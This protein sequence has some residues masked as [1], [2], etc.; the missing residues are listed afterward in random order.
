MKKINEIKKLLI[1]FLVIFLFLFLLADKV[2]AV[3]WVC[4]Y[5]L[6]LCEEYIGPAENTCCRS[7]SCSSNCGTIHYWDWCNAIDCCVDQT[8]WYNV[9]LVYDYEPCGARDT[10]VATKYL[11]AG[12]CD[13]GGCSKGGFYKICCEVNASGN[14]TGNICPHVCSGANYTGTCGS[15]CNPFIG[16]SCPAGPTPTGTPAPTPTP[17]P[18]W[19]RCWCR[20]PVANYCNLECCWGTA[21][22]CPGK[23]EAPT[24]CCEGGGPAECEDVDWIQ[25]PDEQSCPAGTTP[26]LLS[27]PNT[28]LGF[29]TGSL[30]PWGVEYGPATVGGCNWNFCPAQE[31]NYIL[32]D[33]VSND[34]FRVDQRI[35]GLT[36]GKSYLVSVWGRA[37]SIKPDS[38]DPCLAKNQPQIKLI[39]GSNVNSWT[40]ISRAR[41]TW[42]EQV[43]GIT[44]PPGVDWIE[45]QLR[46]DCICD[47]WGWCYQS[48]MDWVR[49]Y[50]CTPPMPPPTC[51]GMSAPSCINTGGTF[52]VS[53]LGVQNATSVKFP[54]WDTQDGQEDIVWYNGVQS[55]STW[56]VNIN[57]SAHP[58][59]NINVHVYMF[60]ASHSNVWC[61]G[62]NDI[63]LCAPDPWFQTKGGDVHGNSDV[64]TTIPPSLSTYF[65]LDPAGVPSTGRGLGFTGNIEGIM[66]SPPPGWQVADGTEVISGFGANMTK[67]DYDYFEDKIESP[68]SLS[69][70][71]TGWQL[72]DLD[73]FYKVG[74]SG[75]LTI[76]SPL[77]VSSTKKIVILVPASLR[78]SNRITVAEGGFVAF[79]VSQDIIIDPNIGNNHSHFGDVVVEGIFIANGNINTGTGVPGHEQLVGRGMFVADANLDGTGGFTFGRTLEADNSTHPAEFFE[80]RPDFLVNFPREMATRRMTWREVAP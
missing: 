41:Y 32:R 17:P 66:S 7:S 57:Q 63:P 52:T 15:G 18:D 9:K 75:N 69:E 46:S 58:K 74:G 53:A 26:N 76:T 28:N 50:E 72:N 55:G 1:V 38:D 48:A 40:Y 47:C 22:D 23:V 78:V 65:S 54:T 70:T 51:T 36:P 80:Y 2:E 19:G 27:F 45:I 64:G 12:L 79:I 25:P 3:D 35:S 24:N 21:S 4:G 5:P 29:E 33:S 42:N 37:R 68:Q 8:N 11:K 31:G 10:C 73:G 60:N 71:P 39:S 56:S 77:T 44:V 43:R 30:P 61:D 13:T 59:G 16:L 67:Y 6:S 20:D 49:I 62:R 34:E 14:F